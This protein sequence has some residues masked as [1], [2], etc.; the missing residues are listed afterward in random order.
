[1]DEFILHL[2]AEE[3][4]ESILGQIINSFKQVSCFGLK[5]RFN[6]H[7]ET[8]RANYM[9]TLSGFR[10][11]K[12]DK[13]DCEK[14]DSCTCQKP[15]TVEFGETSPPHLRNIFTTSLLAQL[16]PNG[17]FSEV[18]LMSGWF[19]V[20]YTP[21]RGLCPSMSQAAASVADLNFLAY[22]K[23]NAPCK[24]CKPESTHDIRLM[25][26]YPSKDIQTSRDYMKFWFGFQEQASS[27]VQIN[28]T[29]MKEE[30]RKQEAAL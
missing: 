3:A 26:L 13:R 17:R 4:N 15:V 18:R 12:H 1:L 8:I 29:V 22:Y 25:G 7:G 19:A 28:Y 27:S 11:L 20:L 24:T 5:L 16:V 2:N 23:V 6:D 9:P 21:Q 10:F 30:I 14:S